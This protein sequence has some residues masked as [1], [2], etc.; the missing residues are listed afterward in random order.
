M[1]LDIIVDPDQA[2]YEVQKELTEQTSELD[3][4]FLEEEAEASEMSY[5]LNPQTLE[6]GKQIQQFLDANPVI[7]KVISIVTSIEI[8]E[9]LNG[10]P[11]D[12]FELALLR[13]RIPENIEGQLVEPYLSEDANQA[14]VKS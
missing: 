7:G 6:K 1:P 4:L 11:F 3:L 10:E 5:W 2:F 9:K 8:V 14:A 12:E 13:K